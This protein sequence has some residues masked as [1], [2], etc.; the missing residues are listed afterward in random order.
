MNMFLECSKCV[1]DYRQKIRPGQR[2]QLLLGI[3]EII[4]V[5]DCEP[6]VIPAALDLISQVARCEAMATGDDLTG[7]HHAAT[8]VLVFEEA[9]ISLFGFGRHPVEWD[10]SAFGAHDNLFAFDAAADDDA[11]KRF[12]NRSF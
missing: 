12:T 2:I 9:S 8:E 5:D 3:V 10:V 6:E 4:D 7:L 1:A 11:A